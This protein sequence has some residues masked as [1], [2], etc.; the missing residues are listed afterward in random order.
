MVGTNGSRDHNHD[1]GNAGAPAGR[2]KPWLPWLIGGVLLLLLLLALR[3][4][5]EDDEVQNAQETATAETMGPR[6]EGTV[7]AN[8]APTA[9][10]SQ[11]FAGYLGGTE[12][13]G[14]AFVLER[15][16]F[17]SGSAL[18]N[19]D[20]QAQ[21]REVATALKGRPSAKVALRGYADPAGDAAANQAL[22][23]Q[24]TDAVRNALIKAGANE[25]Q[26]AAAGAMGE[27]GNAAVEGNRRVEITVTAR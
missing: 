7:T 4:C 27:T 12:P 21:I 23:S 24:R 2:R 22:S 5:G 6:V 1:R 18:L 13:L 16:T 3:S 10:S 14:R 9:W 26:V 11:D 20:A 19:A 15:V 25:A 8:A 17:A